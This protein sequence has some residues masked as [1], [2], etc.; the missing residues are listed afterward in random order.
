[1]K[2]I[3]IQVRFDCPSCKGEGKVDYLPPEMEQLTSSTI[4]L[5]THTIC[6][7]CQGSGILTEWK[8]LEDLPLKAW[9]PNW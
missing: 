6:P 9:G 7:V 1:M 5:Y 2:N 3:K 8:P 4:K